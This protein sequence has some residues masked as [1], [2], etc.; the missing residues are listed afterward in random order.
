MKNRWAPSHLFPLREGL[1]RLARFTVEVLDLL[2]RIE[3]IDSLMH[4]FV[5]F[6]LAGDIEELFR[7][8]SALAADIASEIASIAPK[9]HIVYQM[10]LIRALQCLLDRIEEDTIKLVN[11]LLLHAVALAPAERLSQ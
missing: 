6:D 7:D 9:E 3:F 4:V 10:L 8:V 2:V 5:A 11:V 1:L